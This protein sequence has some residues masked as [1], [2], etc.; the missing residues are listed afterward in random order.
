MIP[1]N[2][3]D[4]V[5]IGKEFQIDEIDNRW[6]AEFRCNCGEVF[7]SRVDRVEIKD[8]RS[9][10]CLISISAKIH[11]MKYTKEYSIWGNMKDRCINENNKDYHNY[12]GR[13]IRICEE[14]YDFENFYRDMGDCPE[15]YTLGR[16]DNDGNYCKENC[17]WQSREEQQRNRSNTIV[18]IDENGDE[19]LV[20]ELAK[21]LGIQPGVI[22]DRLRNGQTDAYIIKDLR[23]SNIH[24][25]Y[26]LPEI[27]R[28]WTADDDK[29]YCEFRCYCGN[30]KISRLDG[31]MGGKIRSCGCL[32]RKKVSLI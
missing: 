6:Y 11:G 20:V 15:D 23:K 12:G 21:E 1:E 19:I 8:T 28:S 9:C 4:P 17:E 7:V 30:T 24:N 10:G 25:E 31:V 32:R 14:W 3:I 26:K 16:I 13:G 2:W 5:Q 18:L 22:Y 27:I 29:S